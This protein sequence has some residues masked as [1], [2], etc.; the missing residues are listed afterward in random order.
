MYSILSGECVRLRKKAGKGKTAKK[1]TTPEKRIDQTHHPT[2]KRH[3]AILK[4]EVWYDGNIVVKYSLAYVDP[5]VGVDNG[6]ILGFD[7]GHGFA[8]RHYKGEMEKLEFPGYAAVA[9]RFEEELREIWKA[10]DE[11]KR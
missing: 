7:N 9:R 3:G 5:R 2:G 1:S 10:E 8:H 6:R 11:Q 4:E